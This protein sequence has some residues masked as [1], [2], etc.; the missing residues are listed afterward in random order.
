MGSAT[1]TEKRIYDHIHHAGHGHPSGIRSPTPQT[2]PNRLNQSGGGHPTMLQIRQIWTS[3]Q[4]SIEY[5]SL[6]NNSQQKRLCTTITLP[7][8]LNH[9]HTATHASYEQSSSSL[10]PS[11]KKNKQALEF[12]KEC[13]QNVRTRSLHDTGYCMIQVTVFTHIDQ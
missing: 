1:H 12:R 8:S 13:P 2:N 7:T 5:L 3:E 4:C 6:I 11:N 10:S 9:I